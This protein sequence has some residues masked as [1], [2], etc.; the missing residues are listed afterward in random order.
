MIDRVADLAQHEEIML[1]TGAMPPW[2]KECL[3]KDGTRVPTLMTG[4]LI[5]RE[6]GARQAVER[7]G[8]AF[9]A[10][11]TASDLIDGLVRSD[12]VGLPLDG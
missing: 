4:A 5:D 12:E 3:R 9:G 10:V 1:A 11:F 2:E 8:Y 6:Q 7:A